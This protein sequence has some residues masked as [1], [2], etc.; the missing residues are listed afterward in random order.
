MKLRRIKWGR[1]FLA[2]VFV[3]C[4]IFMLRDLYMLT[5]HSWF[6]GELVGWTWFGL[7]TFIL[8]AMIAGS[9]YEY[10]EELLNK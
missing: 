9:I 10:F 3:A 1:V 8:V 2:I 5:L 4:C 7:G 6:T